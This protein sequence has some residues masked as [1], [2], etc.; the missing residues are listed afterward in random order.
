MIKTF[1]TFLLASFFLLSCKSDQQDSF[2]GFNLTESDKLLI[3]LDSQT[4]ANPPFV[5]II[6]GSEE[7]DSLL[8]FYNVYNNSIY[9]YDLLNKKYLSKTTLSTEG[10]N[11]IQR[12]VGYH[13]I[14]QDSIF[15]FDMNRNK[16]VL[17]DK[18]GRK[19][20]ESSLINNESSTD[21][22]WTLEYPFFYPQ[23][24]TGMIRKNNDLILTGSYTWAIPEE[25]MDSFKFTAV[26]NIKNKEVQHYHTYPKSVF[27]SEFNWDDPFYTTVYYDWNENE[28]KMVYSFPVSSSLFTG[29]LQ[30]DSAIQEVGT[31]NDLVS[32]KPFGS[33]SPSREEMLNHLIVS[34][35]YQGFKYDQY[36]NVYYRV[37]LKGIPDHG[38]YSDLSAKPISIIIYD[39]EFNVV[40]EKLIG[41][42]ENWNPLNMLVSKDGLL[43][44]YL[45]SNPD[46][47]DFLIFQR[48]KLTSE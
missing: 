21:G 13:I 18:Q 9:W 19:L 26:Y 35:I 46:F 7:M 43:I 40:G 15:V 14:N 38:E 20:D 11:A 27:G 45:D 25:I 42:S 48:F 39:K 2:Q 5:Q 8:T 36:R 33:K 4:P 1:F 41:L 6:K 32:A 16:L 28:Q 44:E 10:E 31:A 47:E 17:I 12:P 37:L 29:I 3:P 22:N 34:D 30:N 23:T 24:V